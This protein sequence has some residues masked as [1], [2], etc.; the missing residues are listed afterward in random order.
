MKFDFPK[1]TEFYLC[2]NPEMIEK[3]ISDLKMQG[4]DKIYHE[5]F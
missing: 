1:G 3:T 5:I 2:G 4:F